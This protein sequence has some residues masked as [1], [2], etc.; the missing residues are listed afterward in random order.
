[1]E[2]TPNIL[3][4]GPSGS[5]KSTSLRNMPRDT[6]F[7]VDLE[8]KP[9]PFQGPKFDHHVRVPKNP[10]HL[11]DWG[12]IQKEFPDVMEQA[13]DLGERGIIE[14]V[15]IESFKK[16]DESLYHYQRRVNT[17]YDVYNNHNESVLIALNKYKN[18]PVP[19]VWT[20][21]NLII[22]QETE[23]ELKDTRLNCCDVMGKVWEGKV[24]KEFVIVLFTAQS[25]E[26]RGKK[27]QYYFKT[28]NS[29]ECT[30]K[31]PMNMFKDIFIENDL[32]AV[33]E[34]MFEY[35][36][37]SEKPQPATATKKSSTTKPTPKKKGR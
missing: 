13:R 8:Q 5:G 29:G 11:S 31:T 27:S 16:W 30:A 21:V 4:V 2:E 22:A 17:G 1:M 3:I 36:G 14:A 18:F 28:N 35:W 23:N 34:R 20:A 26:E 9:L 15:V 6:T 33:F 37:T 7:L 24:E 19:V 25:K 32:A 10:K 12:V